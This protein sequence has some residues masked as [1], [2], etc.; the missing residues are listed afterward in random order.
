MSTIPLQENISGSDD[1]KR[2]DLLLIGA[3]ILLVGLALVALAL[4]LLSPKLEKQPTSQTVNAGAEPIQSSLPN[5]N[6][7]PILFDRGGFSWTL[8]PRAS[9]EISARVLSNKN[10]MDWQSPVIP[11]DLALGWGDMSNPEVDE[12]ISWRQSG[13]WYYYRWNGD[14]PYNGKDIRDHSANVHIVPATDNLERALKTV[15]EGD[16]ILLTGKLVDVIVNQGDH[17]TQ[18][19]TSMT[20]HDTGAGACEILY[21]EKLILNGEAYQ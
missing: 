6:I 9:Y 7:E 11:L 4:L 20:R 3:G 1:Q 14:S 5:G 10:Y 2:I 13:R 17:N 8:T 15:Q 12:W 18:L 16:F 21:V 19:R